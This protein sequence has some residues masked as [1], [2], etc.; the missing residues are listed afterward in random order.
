M[1]SKSRTATTATSTAP[2][3]RCAHG[4]PQ[5]IFAAISRLHR[6]RGPLHRL[7]ADQG[8]EKLGAFQNGCVIRTREHWVE[9]Y[10]DAKSVLV[11][12]RPKPVR[13]PKHGEAR[14]PR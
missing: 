3:S 13:S 12:S 1:P 4:T 10:I 2:F 14:A 5:G 11:E 6:A 8:A 9:A 7:A